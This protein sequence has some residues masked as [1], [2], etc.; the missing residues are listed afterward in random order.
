MADLEDEFGGE[1]ACSRLVAEDGIVVGAPEGGVR[2]ESAQAA[3]RIS[4]NGPAHGSCDRLQDGGE[5]GRVVCNNTA[6]GDDATERGERFYN[7]VEGK[8]W[9]YGSG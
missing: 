9:G 3:D 8:R 1:L 5:I 6:D 2:G 4:K 7:G